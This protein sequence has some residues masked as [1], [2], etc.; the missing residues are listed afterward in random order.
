MLLKQ[1][2]KELIAY[3]RR[4]WPFALAIFAAC[5]LLL[6]AIKFDKNPYEATGLGMAIILFALTSGASVI[7]V[8]VMGFLIYY[9]GNKIED[10]ITPRCY[11]GAKVLATAIMVLAALLLIVFAVF[12]ISRDRTI[13]FVKSLISDWPYLIELIVFLII[14]IP[15]VFLL[16][17]LMLTAS[18]SRHDTLHSFTIVFFI[19]CNIIFI[20]TIVFEGVLLFHGEVTNL[21]GLWITIC[22]LLAFFAFTDVGSFI[23]IC[24]LLKENQSDKKII[25]P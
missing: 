7:G 1:L 15:F 8:Y 2:K 14:C 6:L 13:Q 5:A 11:I 21:K 17:M 20:V 23:L 3:L 22:S 24:K 25:S 12:L 16:L 19:L 9:F 10:N 18:E 4:V